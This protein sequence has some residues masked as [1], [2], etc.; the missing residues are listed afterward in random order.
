MCP[1]PCPPSPLPVCPPPPPLAPCP[2][3]TC[4]NQLKPC[5]S[6][7]QVQLNPSLS[8]STSPH[9]NILLSQSS[10]NYEPLYIT[11]AFV[12]LPYVVFPFDPILVYRYLWVYQSRNMTRDVSA[13][14]LQ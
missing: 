5:P 6:Y 13:A 9:F 4:V 1:T 3:P 7:P 2:P 11:I 8:P 14:T 10:V 12:I